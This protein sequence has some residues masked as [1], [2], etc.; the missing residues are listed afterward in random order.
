MSSTPKKT[1]RSPRPGA[2]SATKATAEA[3]S[4]QTTLSAEQIADIRQ[5]TAKS[6]QVQACFGQIITLLL[7]SPADRQRP[8]QDLEWLVI[9]AVNAG[10]VA[11]AE[12]HAKDMGSVMPIGAILWALVSKDVDSRLAASPDQPVT[13]KP[14]DWRSG[15]IPWIMAAMGEPKII[16]GLLQQVSKTV[17]KD[18]T[19]K[20]RVRGADGKGSIAHLQFPT[21]PSPQP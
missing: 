10:Q 13:L 11:V 7:R 16:Q 12:A 9:P 21:Q 19:P 5:R 14:E 8:L 20:M 17:F 2:K 1:R 3:E 15:D 18:R 4:A 6:K